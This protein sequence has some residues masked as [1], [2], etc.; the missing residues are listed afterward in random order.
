MMTLPWRL[1][2]RKRSRC[3]AGE[4]PAGSWGSL[5]LHQSAEHWE[6]SISPVSAYSS[7]QKGKMIVCPSPK[8]LLAVDKH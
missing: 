7:Q 3:L 6:W 8:W 4:Q 5:V 1:C 2:P